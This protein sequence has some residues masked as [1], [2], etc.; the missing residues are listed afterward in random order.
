M[1]KLLV[2]VFA[3]PAPM[4]N[5]AE[6]CTRTRANARNIN[7]IYLDS[8]LAPINIVPRYCASALNNNSVP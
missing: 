4:T 7:P 5:P 3:T 6:T 1:G 2:I 8:F